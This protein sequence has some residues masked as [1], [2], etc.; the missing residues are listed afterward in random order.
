MCQNL[1]SRDTVW[2]P[3]IS[4]STTVHVSISPDL[5]L[6]PSS[7]GLSKS[8]VW[9]T[10]PRN[11]AEDLYG[12]QYDFARYLQNRACTRCGPRQI[13]LP[14]GFSSCYKSMVAG[15]N[16]TSG[17]ND[18]RQTETLMRAKTR[19]NGVAGLTRA[20]TKQQLAGGGVVPVED[21]IP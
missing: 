15:R 7:G 2:H 20:A 14:L 8:S 4:A 18:T 1:S 13:S 11:A 17:R 9:R 10:R 21:N 19:G 6:T 3:W 12:R 16:P 5:E